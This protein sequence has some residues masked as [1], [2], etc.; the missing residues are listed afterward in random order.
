[1]RTKSVPLVQVD[2]KVLFDESFAHIDTVTI[3]ASREFEA[4][5]VAFD[6][7]KIVLDP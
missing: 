1:M 4:N 5:Q 7:L 6:N 2:T 3:R